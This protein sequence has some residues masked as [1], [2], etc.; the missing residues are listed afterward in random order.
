M[1]LGEFNNCKPSEV[2]VSDF[3]YVQVAGKWNYVCFI[4]DLYNR[5]IIGYSAGQ[6][7]DA[8][9]VYQAFSSVKRNLNEILILHIDRCNEFENKTIDDVMETVEIKRSCK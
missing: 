3:T 4:L 1:K 6:K 2:V 7:N 9:L 5:E 8:M